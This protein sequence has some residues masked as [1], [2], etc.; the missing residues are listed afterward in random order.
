MIYKAY[1][2]YEKYIFWKKRR[3][4][5]DRNNCE[6]C[7]KIVYSKI[8]RKRESVEFSQW[9]SFVSSLIKILKIRSIKLILFMTS[10]SSERK[11]LIDNVNRRQRTG[12]I[13][14]N[15]NSEAVRK[16]ESVE[17]SQWHQLSF[18]V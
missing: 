6:Y 13:V 7:V 12:I 2:I 10:T 3:M 14:N 8:L 18:Q 11:G 17:F 9:S 4:L 1:V 5:K 16:R 15:C